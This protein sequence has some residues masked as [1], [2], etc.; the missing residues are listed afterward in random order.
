MI[1]LRSDVCIYVYIVLG[2]RSSRLRI[3]ARYLI[4]LTC[5][6]VRVYDGVNLYGIIINQRKR[7]VSRINTPNCMSESFLRSPLM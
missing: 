4:Q 3:V 2:Q 7:G 6:G 5:A 1:D